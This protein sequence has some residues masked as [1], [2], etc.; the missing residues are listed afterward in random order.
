MGQ[1]SNRISRQINLKN[2]YDFCYTIPQI[3]IG[4]TSQDFLRSI[5]PPIHEEYFLFISFN[6]LKIFY[7]ASFIPNE[8][9]KG[10]TKYCPE[11]LCCCQVEV[12]LDRRVM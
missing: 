11:I 3:A 9:K 5:I 10:N 8:G 1:T 6:Y 7:S 4:E 2:Y 12:S